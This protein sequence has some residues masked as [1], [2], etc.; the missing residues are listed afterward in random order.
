MKN[1]KDK[2]QIKRTRKDNDKSKVAK[3]KKQEKQ[4]PGVH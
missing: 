2:E 3:N 1:N 4:K